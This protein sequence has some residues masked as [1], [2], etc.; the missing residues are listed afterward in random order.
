[1]NQ[2]KRAA[3]KIDFATEMDMSSTDLHWFY[4]SDLDRNE[5]I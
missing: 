5:V 1:M 2:S 3:T 4:E